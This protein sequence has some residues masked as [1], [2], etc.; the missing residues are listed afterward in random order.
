MTELNR[1]EES[2]ITDKKNVAS[3]AKKAVVN[4]LCNGCFI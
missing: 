4:V 2:G 3:V 1:S